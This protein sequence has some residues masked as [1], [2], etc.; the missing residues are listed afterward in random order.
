M[1]ILSYV[2]LTQEK[3]EGKDERIS[4]VIRMPR[5]PRSPGSIWLMMT[6]FGL[7]GDMV[8]REAVDGHITWLTTRDIISVNP[9]D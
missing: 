1:N 5:I 7:A 3:F 8:V 4:V 2:S 9:S 6:K